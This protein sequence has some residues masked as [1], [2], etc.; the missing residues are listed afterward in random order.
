MCIRD[1]YSITK[2]FGERWSGF[3]QNV[4]F[5]LKWVFKGIVSRKEINAAEKEFEITKLDVIGKIKEGYYRALLRVKDL[6]YETGN[7][8]LLKDF[9]EKAKL[10][11]KMGEAPHIEVLKARVELAKAEG[12][13]FVAKGELGLAYSNLN[14][15]L[16]QPQ[17]TPLKLTD[18]LVYREYKLNLSELKQ[19]AEK[20]HPLVRSSLYNLESKKAGKS[21][22]YTN[23]LPDGYIGLFRMYFGDSSEGRKWASQIGINFPVFSILKNFGE[24]KEA[25]SAVR[26][27]EAKLKDTKNQVFLAIEKAYKELIAAERQVKI[28]E[29]GILAQAEEM[30]RIANESYTEGQIGYIELLEAQRTLISTR[31]EYAFSLYNYQVALSELIK[32]VGGKLPE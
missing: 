14:T 10:R 3:I 11:Y 21:L 24:V 31:K 8:K 18:Q 28:Y 26:E 25:K 16:N 27:A 15:L 4:E 7:V 22:A 12:N 9:Y 32:A 17:D 23:F 20:N 13:Q 1:R 2:N 6:E 29:G 19:F 5:P 30:Y